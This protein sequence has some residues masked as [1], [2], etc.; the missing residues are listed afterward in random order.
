[1]TWW[2][3]RVD[4]WF[5]ALLGASFFEHAVLGVVRPMM[6]YRGLEIG[7]SPAFLGVVAASFA[8]VP[9]AVALP[10]GRLVDRNRVVPYALFGTI[11]ML[12]AALV[13]VWAKSVPALLICSA[14]FG[15]A[16]L[17]IIVPVQALVA[18][19]S[20]ADRYDRRY[21]NFGLAA[22]A[23]Q[24]VGPALAGA[25]ARD[26]SSAGISATFVLAAVIAVLAIPFVL[27][28]RG[29]ER[30]AGHPAR[31]RSDVIPLRSILRAPGMSAAMLASLTI[32]SAVDVLTVYLPAYGEQVGWSPGVVGALL[33][34]R[35]GASMASRLLL[36]PVVERFGRGRVLT[37]SMAVSATGILALAFT[38]NMVL[39]FVLIAVAGMGLGMGQPLT[40]AS[41]AAQADPSAQATALTVRLMGN[42]VGQ[43]AVP[44]AAVPMAGVAGAAG[45]LA[46]I[47]LAVA[48][49][50]IVILTRGRGSTAG[51]AEPT[52]SRS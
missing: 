24:L 10:L 42:R 37:A 48:L 44:A 25:T 23:G 9:L 32:I 28:M 1:M 4:G 17:A 38:G 26:G 15:L 50:T 21:A 41:V 35:A 49:N 31:Q 3:P 19:A 12:A 52:A 33:A 29:G 18:R 47:G 30:P 16:H 6:S 36:G 7:L 34:V 11:A 27:G 8:L 22:A 46:M 43:V 51:L 39:G 5:L 14:A 40:M 45:V 20:T 13:L 2:R